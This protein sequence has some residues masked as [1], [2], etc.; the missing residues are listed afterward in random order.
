MSAILGKAKNFT[1]KMLKQCR[2]YASD[3]SGKKWPVSL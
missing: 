2:P 1:L 3:L